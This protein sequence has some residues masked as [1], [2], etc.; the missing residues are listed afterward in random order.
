[1]EPSRTLPIGSDFVISASDDP[2]VRFFVCYWYADDRR[3]TAVDGTAVLRRPAIVFLNVMPASGEPAVLVDILDDSPLATFKVAFIAVVSLSIVRE[4]VE[5]AEMY[6]IVETRPHKRGLAFGITM[7][8]SSTGGVIFLI[9]ITNLISKVGFAWSTRIAAFTIFGLLIVANLT[10]KTCT[11][12]HPQ[13]SI[14]LKSFSH[15]LQK[16][17]TSLQLQEVSCSYSAY[18]S[19][20]IT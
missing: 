14:T 20:S 12:P 6:K 13:P 11:P 15:P 10:V 5:E 17:S 16:G 8:G 18:S 9:M 4:A 2:A 19:P 1:M 7:S 3:A